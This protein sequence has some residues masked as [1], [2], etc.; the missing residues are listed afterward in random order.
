M[1]EA[2][3]GPDRVIHVPLGARLPQAHSSTFMKTDGMELIRLVIPDSKEIPP[4]RAPGEIMV[5]CIEG[6]VA[7]HHDRAARCRGSGCRSPAS[8]QAVSWERVCSWLRA[9]SLRPS[10]RRR[11]RGGARSDTATPLGHMA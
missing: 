7:S 9:L 1:P 11:W 10:P 4:P 6:H 2:C 5:Q 8:R 3:P